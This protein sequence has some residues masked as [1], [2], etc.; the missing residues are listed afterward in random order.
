MPV[1][2]VQNSLALTNQLVETFVTGTDPSAVNANPPSN[3]L[4]IQSQLTNCPVTVPP[5]CVL[6]L[7]WTVFSVPKPALVERSA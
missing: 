3:N 6:R 5:Y 7:E 2:I 4:L 1:Q